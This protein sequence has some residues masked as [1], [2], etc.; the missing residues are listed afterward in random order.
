MDGVE[1]SDEIERASQAL[2]AIHLS[3]TVARLYPSPGNQPGFIRAIESL[4]TILAAGELRLEVTHHHF[5]LGRQAV[6][7]NDAVLTIASKL[8]ERGVKELVIKTGP[9]AGD[10]VHFSALLEASPSEIEE[11][12]GARAY[13]RSNQVTAISVVPRDLEV[14]G[15]E[16]VPDVEVDEILSKLL[17]DHRGLAKQIEANGI[18]GLAL[19]ELKALFEKGSAAGFSDSQLHAAVADT[20]GA[21]SHGFRDAVVAEAMRNLA[22]VFSTAVTG[23]LSDGELAD[24]LL[25]IAPESGMEL[26]M[27]YAIQVVEN[28]NGRRSELP[29]I[30]GR[31]LIASGFDRTRILRTFGS[32]RLLGER[33]PG[34]DQT[35]VQDEVD[36]VALRLE[37]SAGEG[38]QSVDI[39]LEILSAL[40]KT[41]LPDQEFQAVMDVARTTAIGWLDRSD[42]GGALR[43]LE[44]L[45]DAVKQS[46][47]AALRAGVEDTLR[48]IGAAESLEPLMDP[49]VTDRTSIQ[50]LDLLGER[51]VEPLLHRLASE[52]DANRRRALVDMLSNVGRHNIGLLTNSTADERW[53]FVRNI[54]SILGNMATPEVAPYLETMTRHS[55]ARVRREA[56]RAL[57]SILGPKAAS[58]NA[59]ALTD[60]E[61]SVRLTAIAAL[62][63]AGAADA[64][65]HLIDFISAKPAPSLKEQK[66][67]LTSLSLHASPEALKELEQVAARRWPPTAKTRQLA[68]H[69]RTQLSR[70]TDRRTAS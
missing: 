12:G 7:S 47:N 70:A 41:G 17:T 27:S 68:S 69:A 60:P 65:R 34:I 11:A 37:A 55:D 40:I 43:L 64:P 57:T 10:L 39:G 1:G 30:V 62:G 32:E 20:V 63:G 53:Y 45:G 21:M 35:Q 13:L 8:F 5:F 16:H 24:A 15:S 2:S 66:E 28:S 14:A 51:C 6:P 49:S 23:Q 9:S 50:I 58:A 31:R 59:R 48:S 44:L 36:I 3:T 4:G 54:A 33:V 61:E 56:L 18:P 22:D 38:S 52:K 19:G 46:D 67:A 25:S 26:V 42:F 29:V